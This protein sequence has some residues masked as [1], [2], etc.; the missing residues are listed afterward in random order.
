MDPDS[1]LIPKLQR[2]HYREIMGTFVRERARALGERCGCQYAE[3]FRTIHLGFPYD[4]KG[5]H[6]WLAKWIPES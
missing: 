4:L 5:F 6:E 3:G 1:P 2:E